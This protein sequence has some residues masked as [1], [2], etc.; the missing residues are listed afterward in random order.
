MRFF[1]FVNLKNIDNTILICNHQSYV[2]PILISIPL[3]YLPIFVARQTLLK[4]RVFRNI[5]TMFD[6]VV[7]IPRDNFSA[8]TFKIVVSQL[9]NT[10]KA[11]LIYP[12]GT[13]G[14]NNRITGFKRG[15][16]VI[17]NILHRDINLFYIQNSHFILGKFFT[18]ANLFTPI[19]IYY[20]QKI[21]YNTSPSVLFREVNGYYREFERGSG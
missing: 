17:A 14:L 7:F 16:A 21:S 5:L 11:V 1:N 13:R 19:S 2:D 9:K 3:P 4:D 10:K 15:F 12:E 20:L 6:D 8:E 18:L